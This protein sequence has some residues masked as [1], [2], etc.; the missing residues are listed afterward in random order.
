MEAQQPLRAERLTPDREEIAEPRRRRRTR[1]RRTDPSSRAAR[2]SARSS[3]GRRRNGVAQAD[4]GGHDHDPAVREQL[5]VHARGAAQRSALARRVQAGRRLVA[6]TDADRGRHER[7]HALHAIAAACA[8]TVLAAAGCGGGSSSSGPPTI[9]VQAARTFRLAHFT[10][11]G[12]VQ[13]GKP[14]T[15]SFTI[16][17]PNGRALTAVQ[18]RRRPAQRHPPDHRPPRPR[19]DHPSAPARR[20][21]R[22]H[23]PDRHVPGARPLPRRDRRVPADD[24]PAAELP[25]LLHDHGRGRLHAP[26]AAALPGERDRRR[27]PL[28]A[29]RHAASE[30]DRAGAA[31]FHGHRPGRQARRVHAVVRR[32]RARD[33]LP[34][35]ARSTTSTR[36]CA[37][38][39]PPAARAC[40]GRRG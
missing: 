13:A 1:R 25:A 26:A 10:P 11:A 30:G 18:A 9:A 7:K 19:H 6:R 23:Q 3:R 39:A 5:D 27:L 37:L 28:D 31:R 15:V 34:T 20:A 24:G 35:A 17:Q 8:L 40:S 33:L 12:P 32:A 21:G 16:L 4:T 29:A 2:G 38:G 14:T 22:A 36:T